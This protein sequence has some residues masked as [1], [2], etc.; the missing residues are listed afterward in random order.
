MP[1]SP[2]SSILGSPLP[3]IS[4]AH[5]V[6]PEPGHEGFPSSV[7]P[8]GASVWGS[9][10]QQRA[11]ALPHAQA[12]GPERHTGS[13]ACVT[14]ALQSFA[15]WLREPWKREVPAESQ[16]TGTPAGQKE[17]GAR[18]R[19]FSSR[20]RGTLGAPP[21]SPP[22]QRWRERAQARP[23]TSVHTGGLPPRLGGGHTCCGEERL[24]G[25][26]TGRG[27]VQIL[28]LRPEQKNKAVQGIRAEPPRIEK[29]EG[30]S[31]RGLPGALPQRPRPARRRG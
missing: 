6:P 24:E 12:G 2:R 5:S 7:L 22:T 10:V 16:C 9:A 26:Q 11:G 19:R 13:A 25:G 30:L 23:V 28:P 18:G 14:I 15:L 4:G 3:S 1:P 17:S 20:C 8:A 21:P 29:R 27:R 31:L